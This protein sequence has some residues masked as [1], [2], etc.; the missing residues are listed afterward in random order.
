ML[1]R[2]EQVQAYVPL[3]IAI[4]ARSQSGA[5]Y[6]GSAR[7]FNLTRRQMAVMNCVVEGFSNQ[8]I[9]DALHVSTYTIRAHLASTYKK[10]KVKNRVQAANLYLYRN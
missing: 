10:L 7:P 2:P 6:V 9:A 3:D 4:V 8:E 5:C 1:I